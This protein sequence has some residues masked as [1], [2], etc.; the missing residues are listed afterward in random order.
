MVLPP[1]PLLPSTPAP[2]LPYQVSAC[3][4]LLRKKSNSKGEQMVRST[5]V[6]GRMLPERSAGPWL[7]GSRRVL[8][9]FCTTTKVMAG[10]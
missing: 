7:V 6:P 3:T 8:W 10:E 2:P 5:T 1:L 9:R 4:H